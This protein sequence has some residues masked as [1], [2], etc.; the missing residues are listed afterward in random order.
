MQKYLV[1]TLWLLLCLNA[2]AKRKHYKSSTTLLAPSHESLVRQ[3]QCADQMQLQRIQN[4]NELKSLVNSG[5][6]MALPNDDAVRV[7]PSLPENRR[8]ALP[9]TVSFLHT[10]AEAYREAFGNRLVVDSAVRPRSVQVRLRRINYAAAPADGET[11]SVHER[12][13]AV[14]LSKRMPSKQLVWLRNMLSYYQAMSIVVVEE[15]RHCFHIEV[16]GE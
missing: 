10:F 9:L 3:N 16:I 14:D 13:S 8:Y 6:L 4:E 11:A 12:G 7:A 1:F 15:E 2:E 5:T